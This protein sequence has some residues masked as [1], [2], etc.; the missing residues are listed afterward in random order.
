MAQL[1]SSEKT[2]IQHLIDYLKGN[3]DLPVDQRVVQT[4]EP[5]QAKFGF[6]GGRGKAGLQDSLR[7]APIATLL[8]CLL[9]V[10]A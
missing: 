3:H 1:T 8:T 10:A 6:G 2:S 5:L 4:L 9:A 7:D